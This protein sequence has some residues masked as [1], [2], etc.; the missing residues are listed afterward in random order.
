MCFVA[1]T[2]VLTIKG[3]KNIEEL[4]VG[5]VVWSKDEF[6]QEEAWKPILTPL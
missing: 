1:G 2:K 6:T 4:Q 3:L 5:D